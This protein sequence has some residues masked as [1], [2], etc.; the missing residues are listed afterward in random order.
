M[1]FS[2]AFWGT[3]R[4]WPVLTVASRS[5]TFTLG[6]VSAD[7]AGHPASGYGSFAIQL[8]AT[9]VN[10][11]WTPLSPIEQWRFTHF[12]I[13]T[14]T[15]N[16]ADNADPDNDGV[17]NLVEFNNFT[18]P[19]DATSLP[20]FVWNQPVSGNWTNAANWNLGVAPLSN[21]ATKLEFLSDLTTLSAG[22]ITPNNDNAGI[23]SL[24]S[25]RLAGTG[26]GTINVNPTGGALRFHANGEFPRR[27][28][29]TP[30]RRIST[31]PSPTPSTSPPTSPS[32]A[33]IPATSPSAAPSLAAAASPAP[34][35]S[36]AS[37]S[38]VPTATPDPPSSPP[39]SPPS[40]PPTTSA[41]STPR[42]PSTADRCKSSAPPSHPSPPSTARSTSPR[43]RRSP[44]TS[45]PPP[46][47]SP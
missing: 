23:F 41:R 24:N 20:A 14:N 38:A 15:G 32:T 34:A 16:A 19:A 3:T 29:S 33:R 18:L 42:S 13:T 5:G 12:G 7:S 25:L 6:A 21:P 30:T 2:D 40:P 1:D 26:S 44:S 37:S 8:T 28:A 9:G 31:T 27:C 10:L 35:V 36:A 4:T 45:R 47:A 22:I 39:A 17:T 46:T 43:T 11:T